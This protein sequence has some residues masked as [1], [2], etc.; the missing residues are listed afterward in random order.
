MKN[1]ISSGITLFIPLA[2]LFLF[3]IFIDNY[4]FLYDL[5]PLLDVPMHLLG[6]MLTAW[7]AYRLLCLYK[8]SF[9]IKIEPHFLLS[10]YIVGMVALV[11]IVWEAYEFVHD[12]FFPRMFSLGA[13]DTIGDILVGLLG[14][15]LYCLFMGPLRAAKNRKKRK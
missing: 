4:L 6:G 8:T 9:N 13:G 5:I 3:N 14:A 15:S 11:A 2:G 12:M 1:N 10:L 7:T